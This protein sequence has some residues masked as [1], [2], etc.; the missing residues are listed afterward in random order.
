MIEF[1][2]A[3]VRS[4][5]KAGA[6]LL[7]GD[8]TLSAGANVTLTQTGQNIAIAAT[9]GGGGSF[10]ATRVVATAAFP[11]KH[12]QVV[13]IVDAA[14]DATKKVLPWVA[15]IANGQPDGG[16]LVDLETIHA[17]AK[18][19]SFDLEMTFATPWAGSLTIDYAVA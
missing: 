16:D 12:V 8:V 14:V 19:G 17:V 5:R 2:I 4:I 1:A 10:A 6:A 18:A 7:R 3:G 9:G 13:N 11:A 15:G